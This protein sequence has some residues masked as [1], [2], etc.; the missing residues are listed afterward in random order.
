[1]FLT[2]IGFQAIPDFDVVVAGDLQAAFQA[3][4]DFLHVIL[5]A[6]ERL[7]REVF[8][9]HHPVADEANLAAALDVAVGDEAPG[10]VA[11]LADLEDLPD[12]RVAVQFLADFFKKRTDLFYYY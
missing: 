8:D 11:D 2:N 6:L 4:F 1:M 10:D 9:D 7:E 12:L 5:H 3:G